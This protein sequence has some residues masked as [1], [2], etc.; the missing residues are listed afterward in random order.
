MDPQA[1]LVVVKTLFHAFHQATLADRASL[2]RTMI[3][4]GVEIGPEEKNTNFYPIDG[5]NLATALR[6]IRLVGDPNLAHEQFPPAISL[7]QT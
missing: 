6:E 5:N 7:A 4:P 1:F 3:E 2:M